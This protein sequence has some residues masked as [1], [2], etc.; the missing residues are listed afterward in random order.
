MSELPAAARPARLGIRPLVAGVAIVI[1]FAGLILVGNPAQVAGALRTA[2]LQILAGV[3]ALAV[4]YYLLQGARWHLLLRQAGSRLPLRR[5]LLLN[6]AGQAMTAILPLGDLAR[7]ALAGEESGIGF[8]KAA[9]T[10][11]VQELL[12]T[13]VLVLATVPGML[14]FHAGA[15]AAVIALA[16][17]GG[18]LAILVVPDLFRPV[19]GLLA[20]T[21]LLSR[22]A[23]PVAQLREQTVILL[24]QPGTGAWTALDAARAGIGVLTLWLILRSL[25][26]DSIGIQGAAF[27][28]GLSYVGGAISVIPGG[29][30]ATEASVV[31]LLVLQGVEPGTAV[32]AALLQRVFTTGPSTVLG[33][34]AWWLVRHPFHQTRRNDMATS[35]NILIRLSEYLIGTERQPVAAERELD[36][37]HAHEAERWHVG[38]A[39]RRLQQ[40]EQVRETPQIAA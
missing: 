39:Q 4:A 6:M 3:L 38:R 22:V 7:A 15:P 1:G 12:F 37:R 27:V 8:G 28:L 5:V 11:T 10:V 34:A 33:V 2:A 40:S 17:I 23:E 9:A 32:A 24:R 14:A 26:A 21:P 16:G 30:G 25:G 18:A 19:H 31:G 20:R 36:A 35:T 13:L 29:V